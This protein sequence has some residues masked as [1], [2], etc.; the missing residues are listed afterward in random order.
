MTSPD[1][2]RRNALRRSA[3]V[4]TLTLLPVT[5]PATALAAPIHDDRI[6][7]TV[8]ITPRA[9]CGTAPT[10]CTDAR[11]GSVGQLPWTGAHLHWATLLVALAL[12][13]GGAILRARNQPAAPP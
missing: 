7:I 10:P 8:E 12:I 5:I 3:V 13:I 4:I 2:R 1:L 9:E 6:T 11:H